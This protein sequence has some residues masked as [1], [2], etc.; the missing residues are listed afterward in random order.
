MKLNLHFKKIH[1]KIIVLLLF[2]FV[3][4]LMVSCSKTDTSSANVDLKVKNI[5]KTKTWSEIMK[6]KSTATLEGAQN[7]KFFSNIK[8]YDHYIVGLAFFGGKSEVKL[9]DLNGRYLGNIGKIGK[10]PGEYTSA[11]DVVL[12]NGKFVV[13]DRVRRI[14]LFYKI[15]DNRIEY[16][17][18]MDI[19]MKVHETEYID[20]IAN[21]GEELYLFD[22]SGLKGLYTVKVMDTNFNII[23]K[24][25]KRKRQVDAIVPQFAFS[26][27][28]IFLRGEYN[29]NKMEFDDSFVYVYDLK[30]KFV[31]KIDSNQKSPWGFHPDKSGEMVYILSEKKI[32]LVGINGKYYG[33]IENTTKYDDIIGYSNAGSYENVIYARKGKNGEVVA[34]IYDVDIGLEVLQ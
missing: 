25:H 19:S 1:V 26:N 32:D 14:I 16:I 2:I 22:F 28:Y 33:S 15:S 3:I 5:L 23:N 10:G 8:K 6:L 27:R 21:I 29:Y 13:F 18:E 4:G 17:D 20:I 11:S 9:W 31:R 34:E 7:I 30:G 12:K 24:F